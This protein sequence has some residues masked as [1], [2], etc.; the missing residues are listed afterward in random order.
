MDQTTHCSE[1]TREFERWT[2]NL[3]QTNALGDITVCQ[4]VAWVEKQNKE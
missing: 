2:E 1:K 3:Q 4:I